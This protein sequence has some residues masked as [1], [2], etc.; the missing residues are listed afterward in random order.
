MARRSMTHKDWEYVERQ[1]QVKLKHKETYQCDRCFIN[2]RVSETKK[3]RTKAKVSCHCGLEYTEGVT[4]YKLLDG[5]VRTL[6][7][8]YID[9]DQV[10]AFNKKV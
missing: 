1:R 10:N 7:T 4:D 9:Q 5:K 8:V 6:A 3:K 2:F